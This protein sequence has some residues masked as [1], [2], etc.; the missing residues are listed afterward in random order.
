[1]TEETGIETRGIGTRV[2]RGAAAWRGAPL[3]VAEVSAATLRDTVAANAW[4]ASTAALAPSSLL[5]AARDG[6][7]RTVVLVAMLAG[8]PVGLLSLTR[9]KGSAFAAATS[10]PAMLA[11]GLFGRVPASDY[12]LLGGHG[13]LVADALV[14]ADVSADH[15]FAVTAALVAEGTGRAERSGLVAAALCVPDGSVEAF[16]AGF[17]AAARQEVD[18]AWTLRVPAGGP[19][20]YLASLD[21]GR[22]SV[23][24][25]DWRRLDA[26]GVR[27][28][29]C[30]AREAVGEAAQLVVNVKHRHGV[31][32]H[33][34][35]AALRLD[36]WASDEF[37]LRTAFVVRG[38]DRRML[39][40]SFG[41]RHGEMLEMYEVGLV[42]DSEV[43][44]AAYTEVLVYAPL[45]SAWRTGCT[46]VG[47]GLGSAQPKRLRGAVGSPVWAVGRRNGRGSESDGNPW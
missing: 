29:E 15:R 22:R 33:P 25:R 13:D 40:V 5:R 32:D 43:R 7:W 42:D 46:T 26:L 31:A 21:H 1:M 34:R 39:A 47:L 18:R 30:P 3:A 12:L 4:Q 8:V 11:P 14:A 28:E 24:R 44:H 16:V 20:G 35:L 27:A 41:C 10:D 2:S 38:P 9:L 45:R 19:D 6:R 36:D 17:G 37:G 23:V